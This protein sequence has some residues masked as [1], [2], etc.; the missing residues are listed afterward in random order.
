MSGGAE[1]AASLGRLPHEG[2]FGRPSDTV[3]S[4]RRRRV[5][6]SLLRR[7]ALS[8]VRRAQ[9]GTWLEKRALE[10]LPVPYFHLVFTLPHELSA[11]AL[12]NRTALYDLLMTTAWQTLAQLGGDPKHLE[13]P[14]FGAIAVLHTWGQQLEHHPHVHM[15]VPG[16]GIALDG[17]KWIASRPRF[18][19]PVKVLGK[20]FRGKFLAELRQ[21]HVS[22]RKR[23]QDPFC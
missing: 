5:P 21:A 14:R 9:A 23:C 12:G 13:V 1:H 6:L 10:Q 7:S 4:V 15:I 11:L 20:L 2:G 3:L 8:G 22:G 19:L 18:L 17:S 16:G